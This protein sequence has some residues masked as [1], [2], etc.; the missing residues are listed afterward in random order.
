MCEILLIAALAAVYWVFYECGRRCKLKALWVVFG[1]VPALLAPVWAWASDLDS[2]WWIKMLSVFAGLC[3]AGWL[4]FTFAGGIATFR[5]VVPWILFINVGE[6]MMVDLL[7]PGVGHLVNAMAAV[8]LLLTIP[9]CEAGVRVDNSSGCRD[10]HYD[11][12]RSWIV[13]YTLWNWSFVILNYPAYAG[14]HLAIL[15]AALIV[16]CLNPKMWLQVRSA[17]LGLTLLCHASNPNVLVSL[18]DAS[19]WSNGYVVLLA[20][21]LACVWISVSCLDRRTQANILNHHATLRLCRE[22]ILCK[23]KI[24]IALAQHKTL[25]RGNREIPTQPMLTASA[26]A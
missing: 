13:G 24:L 16:G 2:F 22:A 3:W 8:M 23:V 10:L 21:V 25:L 9:F 20:P 17:T 12:P 1:L 4:R 19:R 14:H 26:V 15:S 11:L 5:S 18:H 7:H 6:A